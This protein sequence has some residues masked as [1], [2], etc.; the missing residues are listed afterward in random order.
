[1][2]KF[3]IAIIAFV[4]GISSV[5]ATEYYQNVY[6][7][8]SFAPDVT[9]SEVNSLV[10]LFDDA[11][12]RTFDL[13]LEKNANYQLIINNVATGDID[14]SLAMVAGDYK[15]KYIVEPTITPNENNE[16]Y[17]DLLVK[18]REVNTEQVIVDENLWNYIEDPENNPY[19]YNTITESTTK[20]PTNS[21]G[22]VIIPNEVTTSRTIENNEV[23]TT[24]SLQEQ[25]KRI[26]RKN[27][28]YVVLLG[29]IGII[30]TIVIIYVTIK[31][32]R[33]N[34]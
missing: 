12:D 17:I 6:L 21:E 8:T 2:K 29:I 24:S 16:L 32:M 7:R 20:N 19:P 31:F 26:Q 3:L 15:S 5:H 27:K 30:L 13:S 22:E 33:A 14:F 1:M 9:M 25:K 23:R 4:I 18:V 28:I 11:T 10:V 34:K